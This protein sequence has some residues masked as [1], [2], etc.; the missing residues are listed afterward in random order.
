DWDFTE[1]SVAIDNPDF[2]NRLETVITKKTVNLGTDVILKREKTSAD[3]IV[4]S[5]SIFKLSTHRL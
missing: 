3:L 5:I 1:L 2:I 4:F